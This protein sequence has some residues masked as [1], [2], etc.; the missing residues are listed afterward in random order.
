MHKTICLALLCLVGCNDVI[1][2]IG[3][4]EVYVCETRTTCLG[5]VDVQ[6]DEI[7]ASHDVSVQKQLVIYVDQACEDWA[8]TQNCE[9]NPHDRC[10]SWCEGKGNTEGDGIIR[11]CFQEDDLDHPW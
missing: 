9:G 6:R 5:K 3:L 7:C 4:D 10:A 1:N 8:L 11:V 2:T